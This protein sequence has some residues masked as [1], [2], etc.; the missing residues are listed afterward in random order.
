M[1][2]NRFHITWRLMGSL[3]SAA[4]TDMGVSSSG[5]IDPKIAVDVALSCAAR[6]DDHGG[7][8][9][10][11]NGRP[12]D[13]LADRHF[14]VIVDW[15]FDEATALAEIDQARALLGLIGMSCVRPGH[16]ILLTA[17]TQAPG[18]DLHR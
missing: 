5:Y 9:L 2:I 7:L 15:R 10:L 6:S 18:D 11:D 12:L 17:G 4:F 14:I 13:L 1:K 16:P 8:P 3:K